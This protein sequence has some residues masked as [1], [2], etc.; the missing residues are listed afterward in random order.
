MR[1]LVDPYYTP[2]WVAEYMAS[3]LPE[4]TSRVIDLAAGGGALLT[5]ASAR[6]ENL[7]IAAV[8]MDVGAIR[9]LRTLNPDWIVSH[10]D[11]R[12]ASSY[13][14]SRAYRTRNTGYD[15]V[16]LNP[17]FSFRGQARNRV[18]YCG[19]EYR[20]TPA[21]LFVLRALHWIHSGG[22]V[23]AII[24]SNVMNIEG[25]SDLW[26]VW[27]SS[28]RVEKKR[29]LSRNTFAGARTTAVVVTL[30][31][32]ERPRRRDPRLGKADPLGSG[33]DGGCA[34]IEI[35]RGRVPVH[36]ARALA[37]AAGAPFIHTTMLREGSVKRTQLA[38][39]RE[40]GSAG[41]FVLLPRVGK[42]DSSKVALC[43]YKRIVLSDC[44]IGLRAVD[45]HVQKAL[46]D[47]LRRD[48]D[49]L[50][51][52]YTGSCA[53]YITIERLTAW[54]LRRGFEAGQKPASS[55]PGSCECNS[56]REALA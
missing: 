38:L 46:H 45:E 50:A 27:Q 2:A 43:N 4:G 36:R 28:F 39:P 51:L 8:D 41:P 3:L 48:F 52:L 34:C 17:P 6:F 19:A 47:T 12:A 18:E 24:P 14:L 13:R 7:A 1:A 21:T 11:S 54:L 22:V 33:F 9:V 42:P 56:L 40:L 16:L 49:Q 25:D 30:Q 37:A 55:T 32:G 35:I 53:P 20:V 26:R 44:V 10:A 5:A 29:V 31:P 15:A 23:I